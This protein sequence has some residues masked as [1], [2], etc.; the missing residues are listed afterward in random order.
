MLRNRGIVLVS[1]FIQSTLI[2]STSLIS[3]NRL[4]RSVNLVPVLTWK[5]NQVIKYCGN[6]FHNIFN[7]HVSLTSGVKLHTHLLNVSIFSLKSAYLICRGADI[8]KYF[9]E[10]L[11]LRDNE[12]RL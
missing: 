7:M 2:I 5:S 8:S 3:N 9:R 11:G 10:S 6:L 12:S 4:S 1:A